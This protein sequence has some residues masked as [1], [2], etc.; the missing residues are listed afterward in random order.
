MITRQ[1]ILEISEPFEEMY[2]GITNQILIMMAEYIG[3]DI[4]EPIEVW[5]QKRIQEINL[6]LKHTQSIISSGGYLSTT[7]NTL[8]TVIDKTLEDIEPKLQEASKNGLL[9]KTTAYTAS[10]SI[11]ELKKN[12]KEDFL[13]TFNTMGNTMQSMILQTFNKA[14]N[15]VVSAYNT[16]RNE[17]LDEA[18]EKI[19]HRETMQNA[20]ASAIRQIAKENIP[21]FI[22]KAGRKW[23]AEAY[24]NMYVRTNVHNMSIDTVVKRNE[25][26]GNDLFIVSKHS[27][28]RPKC[29]PWQ[30]KIVSKN[31]RRGTT[32]DA[33]GKKV[34][35]IALSSTS[36]GQADGLL[37]INCGHQLYPFIP[38]QSINNVKPLSKEQERE[39]KR[40]YEESQRQR[41]IEREI[42]ASKTQEEMYR[43]AGLR[44]EADK[45]KTVTSQR[46]AKM[47]QF[48]NE[49]GRTRRYD[50]EQIVK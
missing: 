15:N 13:I 21:A 7:N 1:Q 34:S 23:T 8:N 39:N 14:V 28:A 19:M 27:G 26:Y 47:R 29:A 36:Y 38:K 45:Q 10:L 32:T 42:R 48:I 17:I 37:G 12:M 18:T 33:N 2:C 30:G 11:N 31:N 22:D 3:K 9:K 44:D 50:R 46:Q 16:R 35:F 40:I 5:Q 25:D 49:T 20:V 43:K 4:D 6:L 24:V 41:A